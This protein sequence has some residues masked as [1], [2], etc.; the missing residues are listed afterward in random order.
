VRYLVTGGAGFIGSALVKRLLAE[1]HDVRVFDRMSRGKA[2][3]LMTYGT[4]PGRLTI[5]QGDIRDESEFL[6]A[7][8]GIDSI[9]HLAYLQGTQTF[10]SNPAEVLDVAARGIVNIGYACEHFDIRDL[11]VVSSS[12]AYQVASIVPTP[13]TI[14]LTVPD[15]LNPRYSYGGGKI[16]HELFANAWASQELLNR[17]MIVR[18]HNVYGPDMGRDHVIPQF[19]IQM[20]QLVREYSEGVLPFEIQGTGLE[21]RSFCYINDCVEQLSAVLRSAEAGASVWH[22]GTQD[23]RTISAVALEV[24]RCYKREIKII[25]GKLPEGSPPRR[26]PDTAKVDKVVGHAPDVSFSAGVRETVSWY[27]EHG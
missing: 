21:T 26:L 7:C 11:M 25:P 9:I 15:V 20:N 24:A 16:L 4:L 27:Q 13:E 5:T 6:A 22:V 17:A 2:V 8:R 10:Y 1:G 14:P 23:E 12:E 3:R 19:C 18:P